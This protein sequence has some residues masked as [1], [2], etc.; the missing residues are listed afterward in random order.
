MSDP[1]RLYRP[2]SADPGKCGSCAFFWRPQVGDV[3]YAGVSGE[4]RFRFPPWLRTPHANARI[5]GGHEVVENS[6][7]WRRVKDSDGCDLW[8][9][10]GLTYVR[11][12]EWTV[13]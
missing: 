8:R 1:V 11:D 13:E 3:R 9:A 10:S 5:E 6:S 4:C 12:E 2:Q 7:D